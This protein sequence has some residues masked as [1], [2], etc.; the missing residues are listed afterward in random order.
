[1]RTGVGSH[2]AVIGVQA[3]R[4]DAFARSW[5]GDTRVVGD[6]ADTFAEGMAT[7]VTFDLPFGILKQE[8][9]DIVTLSED[10][11][12]EGVR[13]ALRATH[14]LAEGAGA[15]SLMAAM[16]LRDR[17]AGKK[18]VCVMS[19]GNIDRATLLRILP[20]AAPAPRRS[21][22]DVDAAVEA[23]GRRIDD[24]A[25]PPQVGP[26]TAVQRPDE[27]GAVDVGPLNHAARCAAIATLVDLLDAIDRCASGA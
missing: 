16:K 2:A 23:D 22:D 9:D 19:G 1:M 14:N 21:H 12:A 5:Q 15:A 27:L 20:G 10:E 7:R 8:L 26:V 17:L 11:L 13:L 18:V 6:T 25:V 4:A 3:A 24:Q